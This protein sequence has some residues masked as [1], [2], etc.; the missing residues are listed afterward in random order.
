MHYPINVL[1][2]YFINF[3]LALTIMNCNVFFFPQVDHC[4]DIFVSKLCETIFTYYKSWAAR[5]SF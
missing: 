4:F 3:L 5:F 1:T 2:S